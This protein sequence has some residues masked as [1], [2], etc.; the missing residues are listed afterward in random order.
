MNRFRERSVS[1][2]AEHLNGHIWSP[3]R[4]KGKKIR[5]LLGTRSFMYSNSFPKTQNSIT[6]PDNGCLPSPRQWQLYSGLKWQRKCAEPAA[7][8][9]TGNWM[10]MKGVMGGRGDD[11]RKSCPPGSWGLRLAWR[12]PSSLVGWLVKVMT[13][14]A[15]WSPDRCNEIYQW[16]GFIAD[17]ANG[18]YFSALGATQHCMPMVAFQRSGPS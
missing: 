10:P 5:I 4:E 13:A 3:E 12:R 14:L 18:L 8:E 9:R 6:G 15:A 17:L 11:D 7:E 1:T 2:N 16:G